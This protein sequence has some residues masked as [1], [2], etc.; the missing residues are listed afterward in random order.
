[1]TTFFTS[2]SASFVASR[3]LC[4]TVVAC[5]LSYGTTSTAQHHPGFGG[6]QAFGGGGAFNGNGVYNGSGPYPGAYNY[7]YGGFN[8]SAPLGGFNA[9]APLGGVSFGNGFGTATYSQRNFGTTT[10]G[11][12]GGGFN[13]G[14]GYGGFNYGV[15]YGTPVIWSTPIYNYSP[16]VFG[17]GAG[18]FSPNFPS[19]N[20][21]SNGY[22]GF[23]PSGAYDPWCNP[24][25]P[26]A[27]GMNSYFPGTG[28][29]PTVLMLNINQNIQPVIPSTSSYSL[30]DPRVIDELAPAVNPEQLDPNLIEP[31]PIPQ[32]PEPN[33]QPV[34]PDELQLPNPQDDVPVLNEFHAVP[35]DLRVS[36]LTEKIQSLRY[37]ASGDDAFH[38]SDYA[39]ADVFYA[40]AIK[41]APD[42]RAPYLRMAVV[43]I[44]LADFPNATSYLKTGLTMESDASRPWCTAEELYGQKV[45]ERARSHGGPLWNWLAERPLSADRLLLAGTFQKLRGYNKTADEMLALASHEGAEALLV[46]EVT[47]LVATDIGQRAV[48]HDLDRLI[49]QASIQNEATTAPTRDSR[50]KRSVEQA[51]GI[52]MRG[53]LAAAQKD[54]PTFNP[55][56]MT[57]DA[58]TASNEE[59]VPFEI[60]LSDGN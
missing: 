20:Y 38:K 50:Q 16:S 33:N 1:M 19:G 54:S 26:S 14:G 24:G 29:A 18:V 53:G 22:I 10:Y 51:G 27:I 52:F 6:P 46:S 30:I 47:H 60:P 48:S 56:T 32:P 45:A 4:L 36:S 49:E 28:I 11:I 35:R 7:S 43:R 25:W 12:T 15:G 8:A 13:Y 34:L 42:R 2:V 55:R 3:W 21:I 57:S 59:P 39:T 31:P 44:A 17:Y 5:V 9:N 40:T 41:T 58:D 23:V 37:Q